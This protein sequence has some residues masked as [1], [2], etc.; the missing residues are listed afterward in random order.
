MALERRVTD[1]RQERCRGC[2]HCYK[3]SDDSEFLN[4]KMLYGR[5]V[6]EIVKCP[7]GRKVIISD[8]A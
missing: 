7:V 2:E 1:A 8:D 4:C 5:W 6:V 3:F